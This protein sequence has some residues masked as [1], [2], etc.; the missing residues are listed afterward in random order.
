MSSAI[1]GLH[2]LCGKIVVEAARHGELVVRF[3]SQ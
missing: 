2:D 1:A 3:V